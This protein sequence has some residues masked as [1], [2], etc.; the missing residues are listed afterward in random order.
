ME[1]PSIVGYLNDTTRSIHASLIFIGS[2]MLASS[3]T[4]SFLRTTA[5]VP[6]VSE[7]MKLPQTVSSEA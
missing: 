5:P 7:Q 2:S 1:G 6:I 3:L 4:L